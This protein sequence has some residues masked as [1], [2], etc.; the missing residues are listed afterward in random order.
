MQPTYHSLYATGTRFG[1][2]VVVSEAPRDKNNN[3]M[4]ECLCDCGVTAVRLLAGLLRGRSVSCG[5][6]AN[7][8]R[9]KHGMSFSREYNSWSAMKQRCF[10]SACKDYAR[11]GA[12]GITVCA[13]WKESFQVFLEDVG[14]R[15]SRTTLDRFPDNTG[16]Y[17][18]GNV[19]WGTIIQQNR[20]RKTNVLITFM[21]VTK[22][23]IEWAQEI[24]MDSTSLSRRISNWGVEK[25]LTTPKKKIN[26]GSEVV[27]GL[28]YRG[29]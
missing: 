4:M 12:R 5:C 25:A 27:L 17:E 16:N 19:R 20:N 13:R 29:R 24:D 15:A 10:D 8:K 1:K 21:G 22:T 2:L 9:R 28:A 3:R 23:L 7:E 26:G 18:P 14:P 6:D 11:Y